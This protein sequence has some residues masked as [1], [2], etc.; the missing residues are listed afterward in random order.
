LS[1]IERAVGEFKPNVSNFIGFEI[2]IL[3]SILNNP[4]EVEK[5]NN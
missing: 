5:K 2:A 3:L 1:D 4:S